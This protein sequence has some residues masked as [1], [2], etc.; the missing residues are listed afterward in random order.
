MMRKMM[1][2][3]TSIILADFLV[4]VKA[5]ICLE[6]LR[7]EVTIVS[8]PRLYPFAATDDQCPEQ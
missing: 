2:S 5:D 1:V 3:I 6:Q 7:S 8:P 4:L